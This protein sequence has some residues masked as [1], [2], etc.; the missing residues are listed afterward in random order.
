MKV[1]KQVAIYALFDPR[2]PDLICYVGKSTN[3]KGRLKGHRKPG[4]KCM[5]RV[6]NWSRKLGK[7]GIQIE[8]KILQWVEESSWEEAEKHWIAEMRKSNPKLLNV[9]DGGVAWSK[10]IKKKPSP[11]FWHQ[12]CRAAELTARNFEKAGRPDRAEFVLLCLEVVRRQRRK[13]LQDQGLEQL[14]FHDYNLLLNMKPWKAAELQFEGSRDLFSQ[15]AWL[16][17]NSGLEDART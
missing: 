13:I 16:G 15:L 7:Q 2:E 8:M 9:D 11:K 5:Q 4:R 1:A 3:P 6:S 17:K 14:W 10:G 12:I